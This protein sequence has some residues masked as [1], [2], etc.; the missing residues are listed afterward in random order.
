MKLR[1]LI[2]KLTEI[3]KSVCY[4][5][6]PSIAGDVEF[7]IDTPKFIFELEVAELEIDHSMG[8][9]CELGAIVRLTPRNH[10]LQDLLGNLDETFS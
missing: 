8:C 5:A 6:H 9:G 1:D 2:E 4:V 10:K 7:I 3:E